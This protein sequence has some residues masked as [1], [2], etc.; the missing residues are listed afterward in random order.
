[1]SERLKSSI[2]VSAFLRRCDL[3]AIPVYVMQRGDADAGVIWLKVVNEKDEVRILQAIREED[4][5]SGT[6][7]DVMTE[8][9]ADRY[10]ERQ[11]GYDPDLWII[12]IDDRAGRC[13][14]LSF[15]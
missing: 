4:R 9:A 1:M 7:G 12:E 15:I 3:A 2:W 8:E 10:L 5:Y 6:T 13:D 14:S 11:Q